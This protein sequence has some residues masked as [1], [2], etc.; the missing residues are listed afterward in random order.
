M[1]ENSRIAFIG[2]GN[3]ARSLIGGLI[4]DG[5][6]ADQIIVS[7]NADDKVA[8]A[9]RDFRVIAASSNTEAAEQADT[10]VLAVKPQ[11]LK[12]VCSELSGIV[13][14]RNPLIVSIAA[15]VRSGDIKRWL[16]GKASVVRCM[17]NTPALVQAG[18]TGLFADAG[19][20]SDQRTRA[21]S[22]LRAVG[23]TLWVEHETQLD[24]V[25]ALSGSGPAY[26][27]LFMEALQAA[28]EKRG[29]SSKAASLLARQTALGAAKMAIESKQDPASLRVQVT[30][31]GGTTEQAL[32][33]FNGAGFAG[34]VDAAIEAAC[35]RSVELGDMLGTDLLDQQTSK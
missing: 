29:L 14:A 17:P 21:E 15:G 1:N 22:I 30:S 31:P 16:G 7:D 34:M 11:V 5:L 3:M 27:F 2:V 18:A 12:P 33:S 20:E 24:T 28:A 13:K 4:A 32:N 6:S 9:R 25:T 35:Q 8:E 23:L 10:L 19:V 26:F